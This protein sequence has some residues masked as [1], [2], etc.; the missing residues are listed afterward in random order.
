MNSSRNFSLGNFR[1]HEV[2]NW[3]LSCHNLVPLRGAADPHCLGK[4]ARLLTQWGKHGLQGATWHSDLGSATCYLTS[5]SLHFFLWKMEILSTSLILSCG[6]NLCCIPSPQLTVECTNWLKEPDR[7]HFLGVH[8]CLP[9][10][11][12]SW[13]GNIPFKKEKVGF[14][15]GAAAILPDK[16]TSLVIGA[17]FFIQVRSRVS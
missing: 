1:G 2:G 14:V 4:S 15:S 8:P 7:G 11:T 3:S 12:A 17:T 5:L 16:L 13:E 10:W 9:L 6:T